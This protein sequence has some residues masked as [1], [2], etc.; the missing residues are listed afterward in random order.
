MSSINLK[1]LGLG[2]SPAFL[3][4]AFTEASNAVGSDVSNLLGAPAAPASSSQPF[5]GMYSF[6][7][8]LS[9]VGNISALTFRTFPAAPYVNGHFTN[10]P[11]WVEDLAASLG[12]PALGPSVLGG[13]GFAYGGAETGAELLHAQTAGDLPSQLAQFSLSHPV[14]AANA[15]YTS[16]P[17]D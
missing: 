6:G 9:D 3:G 16:C 8:S 10:G 4:G 15:L 5:S 14:P 1:I 11:V 7:D 13:T 17:N 2:S 12:L